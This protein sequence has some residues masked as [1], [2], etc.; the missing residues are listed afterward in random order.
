MRLKDKVAIITGATVGMGRA[1][2]KEG[3]KVVLCGRR[4]ELGRVDS[5]GYQG[6]GRRFAISLCRMAW[7]LTSRVSTKPKSS[8][9][10]LFLG[11]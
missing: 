2:A 1:F 6:A 8:L 4:E 11:P 9:K 7:A 5:R 10:A 3:A